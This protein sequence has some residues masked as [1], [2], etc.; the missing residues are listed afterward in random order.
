MR[1]VVTGLL[2]TYPLG[3]VTWD[4]LAFVQGFRQLGAEVLYLEDTG[5]WFYD[6][7][8]GTFTD[9]VAFHLKYLVDVL[10]RH[11]PG[12]GWS[13]RAPDGVYHGLDEAAVSRFCSS[14][15]LFLNVSGCCWL[16][17]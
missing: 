12:T 4:Y 11:A 14:A 10:A 13:V 9:D 2:A 8:D 7:R 16:R 1:V 15:D 3:G 17:E 6:P 5:Q